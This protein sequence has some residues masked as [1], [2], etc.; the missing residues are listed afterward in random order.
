MTSWGNTCTQTYLR[1]LSLFLPYCSLFTSKAKPLNSRRFLFIIEIW[2]ESKHTGITI[3]TVFR[4]TADGSQRQ[5]EC[6]SMVTRWNTVSLWEPELAWTQAWHSSMEKTQVTQNISPSTTFVFRHV[7]NSQVSV[8]RFHHPVSSTLVSYSLLDQR[9]I[10]SNV[11]TFPGRSNK[12]ACRGFRSVVFILVIW[13]LVRGM[14]PSLSP[15]P[16]ITKNCIYNNT[17][18][19]HTHKKYYIYCILL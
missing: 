13:K 12:M 4:L 3:V 9:L 15:L 7:S 1:I 18:N 5:K 2:W 19:T 14:S 6:I 10:P 8:M 16:E 17:T 11:C